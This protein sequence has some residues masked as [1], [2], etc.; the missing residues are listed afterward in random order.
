L[1]FR[2][3]SFGVYV[4]IVEEKFFDMGQAMKIKTEQKIELLPVSKKHL[5]ALLKFELENKDWFEKSVPPRPSEM[6]TN[7][8]MQKAA[9]QLVVEMEA[10]EG[11]YYIA[12]IEGEVVARINFSIIGSKKAELGYRVA[13]RYTG[14]GFASFAINILMPKAKYILN[15]SHVFANTASDNLAS[16]RVLEKCGF[17]QISI[18][19]DVKKFHGKM[20][21]LVTYQRKI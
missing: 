4:I 19:N 12:L 2:H 13:E 10:K 16:R 1:H 20:I 6:F 18:T 11:A 3:L 8:G 9:E 15:I 17:E 21:E 14:K 7:E 5:S